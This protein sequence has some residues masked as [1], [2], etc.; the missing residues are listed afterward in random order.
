MFTNV[1]I[2]GGVDR[3]PQRLLVLELQ[4]RSSGVLRQCL[5]YVIGSDGVCDRGTITF[6]KCSFRF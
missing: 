2:A 4:L 1:R 6:D 3:N 5:S